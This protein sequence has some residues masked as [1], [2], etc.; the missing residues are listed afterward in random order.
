MQITL[1][2]QDILNSLVA[3]LANTLNVDPDELQIGIIKGEVVAIATVGESVPEGLFDTE[4]SVAAEAE[5]KEPAPAKQTKGKRVRRTRA[6]I[7]ADEAAAKEAAAKAETKPEVKEDTKP[8][9]KEEAVA[10]APQQDGPVSVEEESLFADNGATAQPFGGEQPQTA[11]A[12]ELFAQPEVKPEPVVAQSE[13]GF[14]K[15]AVDDDTIN[16]FA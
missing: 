3:S 7:E 10:P 15:P 14:A 16:L 11:D 6:Q 5:V 9:V 2:T 4:E 12:D 13:A 8:E 1:N